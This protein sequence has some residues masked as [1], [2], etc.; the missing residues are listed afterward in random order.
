M[1]KRKAGSR[2]AWLLNP[3]D[4]GIL[5]LLEALIVF[6]LALGSFAIAAAALWI[7]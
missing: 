5:F 4:G 2:P 3:V 7:L 6:V 1:T